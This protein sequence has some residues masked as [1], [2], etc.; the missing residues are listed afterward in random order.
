[1][2]TAT[3]TPTDIRVR[4]AVVHQLD[5]DPEVDASAIGVANKAGVVTL[6]GFIDTY[7]GKLAAERAA[8]RVRG[9]RG[10]ANDIAVR[11][12]LERNDPDVARDALYALQTR[13]TIPATVQVAVHNRYVTLTGKVEWLHQKVQA[14]RALE[15]VPGILGV[16]NHIEVTPQSGARDIHHRIV[17]ALHRTADVDARRISV[18][19]QGHVVQLTGS[20][21]SWLERDAAELAASSAPG[22]TNV[23]NQI[24]VG[25]NETK[26]NESDEMC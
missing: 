18:S 17:E 1:M 6:T 14:E 10:V 8:K 11:P 12:M 16:R 21:G 7:T 22:I 20:V 25:A 9:V 3:L 4:D 15:H 26:T 5:W 2:T 23:D 24:T 19:I 13:S